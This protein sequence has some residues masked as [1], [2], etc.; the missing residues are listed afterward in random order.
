MRLLF[1]DDLFD[2]QLLRTIGHAAYGGADVGECIATARRIGD[3]DLDAWGI[4]WNEL[5]ERI[6]VIAETSAATGHR[7]SAREAYLR[8]ANYFR[9]AYVFQIQA[10]LDPRLVRAHTRQ[11]DAF[12][13]AVA[14]FD[15]PAEPVAIPYEGTLLHGYF[16][17]PA[18]D[19]KPRPTLIVT[20]GYDSTAEE[21]YFFSGAAAVAR[22]YNCLTYDGPGQGMAI[23]RDGLRFR[24]D[25]ETVMGPVVDFVLTCPGVD[26]KRVAQI[27]ISFGG[28]LGP[29]AASGEPRLAAL[30][31]DPGDFSLFEEIKS[32]MPPFAARNLPDGNP[33]VVALVEWL[34]KSRMKKPTSGWGLRRALWL[35]GIGSPL[36]YV[37]MS[38]A[39]SL[40]GLAGRIAC[41]TLVCQAENDEIGV[42]APKLFEA[43]RCEKAMMRFAAAEGAGEHC[44]GGARTLFNQRSFDWLDKVLGYRPQ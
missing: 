40:E 15:T 24:P 18:N 35:H 11:V 9:T 33:L 5:A 23:I 38:K 19:D 10:P 13:E 31:A 21:S 30:I 1:K 29:R 20:G 22:G 6:F 7:V 4:A 14:L 3:T 8:A 42:T 44:E 25:W 26:P 16:F 36:D 28:Y 37:R 27:G 41:P 12:R 34:M 39:Y 2:A 17:R 32:R 43:L